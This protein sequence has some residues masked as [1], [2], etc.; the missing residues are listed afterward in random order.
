MIPIERIGPPS[1]E[2]FERLYVRR[3]RPVVLRGAI[4]DWPA[5]RHWSSAYFKERFGDREVP[6]ART[7]GGSMYDATNGVHFETIRMAAYVDLL[8]AG[9]PLDLYMLFRVQEVLPEL[10]DDIVR[11]PY[12]ADTSWFRSRFWFAGPDTKSPLHRDLPENLYAQVVGAKT[13]LMLDRR[14]TRMVHRHSFFSGV[15]NF[16]PVD[17]EAP[18]LTRFP[19][20]RD[21][22]LM[23]ARVEA[24]DLFYIPRL[25][26]HQAHSESTS[27]SLSLW[28]VRGAMV[29][30]AR[31]AE[32]FAR[33]RNIRI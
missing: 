22:P 1:V 12:C 20:F 4:N 30:V 28:W 24:G 32:L 15:P 19:R 26:W 14:L 7:K 2:E 29:P 23:V 10:F 17:A 21:A 6:V 8:S 25:W 5:V 3:S 13:F 18:D 16:S 31:A 27:I 11:P 9:A 33:V